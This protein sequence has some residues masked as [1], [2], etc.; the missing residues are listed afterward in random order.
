MSG[1]PFGARGDLVEQLVPI[2]AE[3]IQL[4]REEGPDAVR[5][6]LLRVPAVTEADLTG[7]PGGVWGVFSM[8]C[9]AFASEEITM[10]KALGWTDDLIQPGLAA[11]RQR[12]IEREQ[13]RLRAAGV[14][15]DSA[16]ATLAEP[17][18]EAQESTRDRML[19]VVHGGRAV[20]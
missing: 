20:A 6:A 17:V 10:R 12:M 18:V 1:A 15:T 11:E 8:V 19:R 5:G 14:R 13:A 16:A 4:M 2:A 3:L 9:A 7:V